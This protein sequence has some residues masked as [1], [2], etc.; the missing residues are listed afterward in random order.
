[1]SESKKP[2]YPT[3]DDREYAEVYATLVK[4]SPEYREVIP[5][6]ISPIMKEFNNRPIQLLSIGAGTGCFED[7]L[8]KNFGMNVEYF[9]GIEPNKQHRDQ[10]KERVSNWNIDHTVDQSCFTKDFVTDKRFDLIIMSHVLYCVNDVA[11]T[12]VKVNSLLK[13]N[14]KVVIFH[15]SDRGGCELYNFFIKHAELSC[16]SIGDHA[17]S[18]SHIVDFLKEN[19]ILYEVAFGPCAI[20]V[21]EFIEKRASKNACDVVTFMLQTRYEDLHLQLKEDLY[22]M[23]KQGSK[24]TEDGKYLFNHPTVM[25]VIKA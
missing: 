6:L 2:I 8:I 14:G 10:L 9:Y 21:S 25:I 23:V 22:A 13:P 11:G 15:Q 12:L 7:D 17:I 5:L 3:L 20:D 16:R 4:N 18:S 19:E 1:M 24:L